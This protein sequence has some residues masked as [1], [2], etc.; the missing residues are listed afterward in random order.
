MKRN[1]KRKKN[2]KSLIFLYLSFILN[3]K[4][5][6]AII[7]SFLFLTSSLFFISNIENETD[8]LISPLSFHQSYFNLSLLIMEILNG[9]LIAFF[10][11][12]L[13]INSLNFDTLFVS[14]VKRMKLSLLK[15]IVIILILFVL[16]ILEFGIIMLIALIRFNLF[17][18][19]NDLTLT[20][21]Y[22][23]IVMLFEALTSIALTEIFSMMITPLF[24]LFSFLV[25]RILMNNYKKI[26]DSFINYFPY[27][28]YNSKNNI[29]EFGN[30]IIILIMM[31]F[32]T[33]IYVEIYSIKDLK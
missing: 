31:L 4:T 25:I 16:L 28:I 33:V 10:V 6:I 30:F 7:I 19:T 13:S 15:L 2:Y 18:I 11:L 1:E 8:Y 27:T 29:F 22:N 20:F 14:Y 5:I 24:V 23:F 17:K 26:S 3:K 21:F 9:I 32:L 12:N